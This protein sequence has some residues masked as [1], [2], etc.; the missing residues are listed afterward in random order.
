[1]YFITSLVQTTLWTT[2]T[3]IKQNWT[4]T[5]NIFVI[6]LLTLLSGIWE[7]FLQIQNANNKMKINYIYSLKITINI[8]CMLVVHVCDIWHINKCHIFLNCFRKILSTL[9]YAL[10]WFFC[11]NLMK[12]LSLILRCTDFLAFV[13]NIWRSNNTLCSL[14][15]RCNK[16]TQKRCVNANSFY[17]EAAL[18]A[19]SICYH[20]FDL[21][22][23][24]TLDRRVPFRWNINTPSNFN[25]SWND[26]ISKERLSIKI[27][28]HLMHKLYVLLATNLKWV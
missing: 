28:I 2:I 20:H 3:A 27:V 5:G 21:V 23:V 17:S 22:F 18:I 16:L 25:N 7:R 15:Y 26:T 12:W 9:F 14:P 4:R 24:Q 6:L 13:Y 8:L 11:L 19:N 1:M 10:H